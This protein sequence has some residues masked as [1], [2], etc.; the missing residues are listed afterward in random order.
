MNETVRITL[1]DG[2]VKEMPNGATAS[3]VAEDISAGL[4]RVALAAKV[5]GDL[6][7]LDRPILDDATVEILTDKSPE[8][9]E[10]LRHSTAHVL[11]TAVRELFPE[12]KIGFGPSIED[13]FYYD[14]EVPT[15]FTPDD[16]ETMK[17][18]P[19]F[20]NSMAW[21]VKNGC[22]LPRFRNC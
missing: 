17:S 18:N 2:S 5:N 8:A 13:G 14:F 6:W 11:A 22:A 15:P 19:S 1:P 12:A 10:P 16:L 20:R 7:D 4:A 9:L 3:A 21:A